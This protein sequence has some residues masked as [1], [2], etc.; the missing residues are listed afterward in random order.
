VMSVAR[1]VRQ[2]VEEGSPAACARRFTIRSTS[3]DVMEFGVIFWIYG[4]LCS[5]VPL[6][7]T[8]A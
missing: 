1:N 8:K 3:I 4:T 2:H 7:V 6:E 5:D